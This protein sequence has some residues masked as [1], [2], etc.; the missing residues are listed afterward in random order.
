MPAG[1]IDDKDDNQW[2]LKVGDE[3]ESL[4][5]IQNMVLCKV[6]GI[7]NIRLKDVSDVTIVNDAADTYAKYNGDDTVLLAIFKASTANTSEVSANCRDAIKYLEEKY[8]GV[9][10][11]PFTDQST[12]ISMFLES[13]LYSMLIGRFACNY[14]TGIVLKERA[15][16]YYSSIQYTF[17]CIVCDYN[18][19]FYRN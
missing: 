12:Y 18:Y 16:Y 7:G 9:N 1:Y 10:I 6:K 15:S 17:Q 8:P 5:E 19:V 4:E 13:V 11:V 2:L 3:Y 14:R